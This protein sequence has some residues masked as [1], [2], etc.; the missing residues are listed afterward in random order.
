MPGSGDFLSVAEEG[1][2]DGAGADMSADGAADG[3]DGQLVG[4]SFIKRGAV[5]NVFL[6]K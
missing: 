2:G 1:D 3:V 5:G 4:L 6:Q